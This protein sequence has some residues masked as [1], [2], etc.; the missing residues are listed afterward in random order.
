[1]LA[2]D[3]EKAKRFSDRGVKVFEGDYFDLQSMIDAFTGIDELLL[4]GAVS[5]SNR[6]P[7]HANMVKAVTAAKV[8]HVAYISFQRR[9]HPKVKLFEVTDVEND[10]ERDIKASGI[11]YTIARNTLYSEA[12]TIFFGSDDLTTSG[13]HAFGP[14]GKTTYAAIAD[15]AEANAKLLIDPRH[16]NKSYDLNANKSLSFREMA[17]VIG[18]ALGKPVPFVSTTRE[19]VI[20]RYVSKGVPLEAA[21]YTA[22]F[23]NAVA[24]GDF[25]DGSSVL[26]D[27]LGREPTPLL[28]TFKDWAVAQKA[29]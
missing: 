9:E 6:A 24:E 4:I 29:T 12:Y 25:A 3:L 15:L 22:G 17:G 28:E 21:E 2:R 20:E 10:T 27:I 13:V 11:A 7:Q 16:R 5:R 19:K 26:T 23:L 1:V 8:G 18:E 14:E